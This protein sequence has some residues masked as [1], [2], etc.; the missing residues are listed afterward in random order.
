MAKTARSAKEEREVKS[1]LKFFELV[2]A[3][4]PKDARDLFSMDCVQHNPYLPDG[5]DALLE[6]I[7]AVQGAQAKSTGMTEDMRM[8]TKHVLV[9]GD[10]VAVHMNVQSSSDKSKGFRQMHLFRFEGEKIAEYW[11]VTQVAPGNSPNASRMF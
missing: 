7:A 4:T 9:D 10:L 1:V 11:D 2:A 5:I 6:S 8:E 3:G